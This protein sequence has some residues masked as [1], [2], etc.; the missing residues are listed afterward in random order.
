MRSVPAGET[1]VCQSRGAGLRLAGRPSD[2]KI[3]LHD[4]PLLYQIGQSLTPERPPTLVD[5]A[6]SYCL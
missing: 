4:G 5:Q 1:V 3:D 2:H 6:L